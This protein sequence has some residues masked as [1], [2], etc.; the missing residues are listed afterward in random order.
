MEK[1]NVEGF[2]ELSGNFFNF[3]NVIGEHEFRKA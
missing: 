1:E 3:I 2:S